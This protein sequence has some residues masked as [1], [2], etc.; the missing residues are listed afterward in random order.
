MAFKMSN[1]IQPKDYSMGGVADGFAYIIDSDCNPSILKV[2]RN[3]D[4][5]HL[6]GD[7]GKPENLYNPDYSFVFRRRHSLHFSLNCG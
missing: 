6:N 2:Y 7:N 1:N 4:G 5:L 3:D